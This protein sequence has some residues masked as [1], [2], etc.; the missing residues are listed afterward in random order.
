MLKQP[1]NNNHISNA[2]KTITMKLG[3]NNS[4][5]INNP[6]NGALDTSKLMVNDLFYYKKS[7]D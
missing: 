2:S 4:R 1:N 3:V 7:I 5:S 6:K